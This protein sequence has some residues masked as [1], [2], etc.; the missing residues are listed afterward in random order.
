M[1]Q[2]I[3]KTNTQMNLKKFIFELIKLLKVIIKSNYYFNITKS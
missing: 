1:F 3:N 2:I